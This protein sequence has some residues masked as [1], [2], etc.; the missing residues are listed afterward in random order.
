MGWWPCGACD[1][2]SF[3][4]CTRCVT[5][6]SPNNLL[7]TVSGISTS[8]ACSDSC[9]PLN[10]TFVVPQRTECVYRLVVLPGV[11]G[12]AL[13][14]YEISFQESLPAIVPKVYWIDVTL[15]YFTDFIPTGSVYRWETARTTSKIDCFNLT[16]ELVSII[17]IA[18]AP[19]CDGFTAIIEVNSP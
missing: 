19:V 14:F 1:G 9:A 2:V 17:T 5:G 10:G 15:T 6:T 11:C 7:L 13:F 4:T 16:N 12:G 8:G 18:R 3:P